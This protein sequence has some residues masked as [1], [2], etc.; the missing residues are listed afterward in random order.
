MGHYEGS[1]KMK[2]HTSKCPH[3]KN[4]ESSYKRLNSTA[5]S[6]RKKKKN[7]NKQTKQ[8]EKSKKTK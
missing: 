8:I 2:V 7:N 5:E 3:L 1:A 4:G 6:S